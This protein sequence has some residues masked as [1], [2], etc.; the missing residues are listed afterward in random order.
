MSLK[1][2]DY[3]QPEGRPEIK[4]GRLPGWAKNVSSTLSGHG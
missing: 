1:S 3:Y 4:P 2:S